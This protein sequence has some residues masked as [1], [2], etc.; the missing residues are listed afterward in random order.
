MTTSTDLS[1]DISTI[2]FD[3]QKAFGIT[4]ANRDEILQAA[5]TIRLGDAM[6]VHNFG[7][8]KAGDTNYLDTLL[9]DVKIIDQGQ[10]GKKLN[11]VVELT[12]QISESVQPS[13]FQLAVSKVPVVGP[14]ISRLTIM[15]RR[16]LSRFD[17]VKGQIDILTNGIESISTGYLTENVK[18]EAM[19]NDVIVDV[20]QQGINIV[21]SELAIKTI[22]AELKKRQEEFKKDKSNTLLAVEIN[23][24]EYQLTALKKRRSDMITSQQ[25][26][27]DDL[28]MLRM[29]QQNNLTMVDKFRSIEEMTL[30]AAKRGHL[31]VD[32]LEKQNSGVKL[33]EAIDDTTN[34]LAVRQAELVKENSIRIAKQSHRA[35]YDIETL[36][37]VSK[38]MNETITEVKAIHKSS[39]DNHL[40]LERR[41]AKWQEERRQRLIEGME[42]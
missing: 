34:A 2:Q 24:I 23:G 32:A 30:P 29:I 18:L 25:K 15:Q 21:A 40:M 11:E 14:I 5:S 35:V 4:E 28:T 33:T 31:I 27:Y 22:E 16:A 8:P 37:R 26:S 9:E 20:R 38:L 42:K 10:S 3:Q 7:R 6:S 39:A 36:D 17:S 13:P 12:R 1:L 19:Y 41:A